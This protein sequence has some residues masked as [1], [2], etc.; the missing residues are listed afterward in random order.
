M[1]VCVC[2][3]WQPGGLAAEEPGGEA[4]RRPERRGAPPE[5]EANRHHGLHPSTTEE[6]ALEAPS[7]TGTHTHSLKHTRLGIAPNTFFFQ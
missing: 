1:C 3:P 7:A 4:E 5:E 2:S 6:H